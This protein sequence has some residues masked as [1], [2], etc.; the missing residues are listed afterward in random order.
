V[1]TAEESLSIVEPL[2]AARGISRVVDTTWLDKVGIPVFAS[3]RPDAMEGS[4]CVHAGKGF[5][6]AEAKIGA[7]MEAL[8]FSFAG[9][10]RSDVNW[11]LATP[12]EVVASFS[13]AIKFFEFGAELGLVIAPFDPLAVVQAEEISAGRGQVLVPAELV[14]HPFSVNPGAALFGTGTNGLASGNSLLEATVHGLAEVMERHATSFELLDP[15]SALVDTYSAGEAVNGL[16]SKIHSAGLRCLLRADT[17]FF[18]IPLFIATI[19]DAEDDSSVAVTKG[20]GFHPIAEIG[21]VRAIAEA[22]QSRLTIIHGGRDDLVRRIEMAKRH[23]SQTLTQFNTAVRAMVENRAREVD[24]FSLPSME[25]I[26]VSVEKTLDYLLAALRA[27]GL[28]N[29]ARVVLT[30]TTYPFQVVK[31]I[32]PGAECFDGINCRVGPRLLGHFDKCHPI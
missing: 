30:P 1:R 19:L 14:F 13:G 28:S 18:G 7:Y 10:G 23:G 20:Y 9:Y 2:A 27:D 15:Q 22:A 8:E 6:P 26:D 29:V 24:F 25:T 5:S 12:N 17:R 4:L 32:V 21:A 11:T 31:V 16:L 3:I